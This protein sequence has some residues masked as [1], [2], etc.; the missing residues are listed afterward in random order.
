MNFSSNNINYCR[1]VVQRFLVASRHLS[2]RNSL[3]VPNKDFL[4]IS[5]PDAQKFIQGL[6]TNDVT[7]L[8]NGQQRCV[9][10]S[11]LNTKGRIIA[12]CFMYKPSAGINVACECD[13]T[14]IFLEVHGTISKDLTRYLTMYKLR[15]KVAIKKVSSL[16][17]FL[18]AEP[19]TSDKYKSVEAE[20]ILSCADPRVGSAFGSG[21]V[22]TRSIVAAT[23]E[24][25]ER[26]A[27]VKHEND[28]HDS[29]HDEAV[30]NARLFAYFNVLNGLHECVNIQN[31][32]PFETN[33]DLLNY[34]SLHKGCYI[35]QELVARTQY[36]GVVRKRL[37][38]F[39]EPSS[40][41]EKV[42]LKM[43]NSMHSSTDNNASHPYSKLLTPEFIASLVGTGSDAQMVESTVVKKM[44]G[45]LLYRS[46]AQPATGD[47]S[48]SSSGDSS[49]GDSSGDSISSELDQRRN[50]R[51]NK[52]IGEIFY[53]AKSGD[54]GLAFVNLDLLRGSSTLQQF[55]VKRPLQ[56]AEEGKDTHNEE[57]SK[58]EGE[59][60]VIGSVSAYRPQ[61][62]HDI[63]EQNGL[64]AL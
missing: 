17:S 31:R 42:V 48:T 8:F 18:S 35:G 52:P 20:E 58:P 36:K 3:L 51:R 19:T 13:E 43:M 44:R 60:S 33:L 21:S 34:I 37:V 1:G 54:C 11:F 47:D 9:A 30:H 23:S 14:S 56:E 40:V 26:A 39:V 4:H 5:G 45:D 46:E 24:N 61:F 62:M 16:Q 59:Q 29:D 25:K 38:P 41:A 15:A 64:R 28:N 50:A 53:V 7:P 12:E 57:G 10:N 6:C 49:S 32:I 63:G 55:V 27:S 22:L 2:N